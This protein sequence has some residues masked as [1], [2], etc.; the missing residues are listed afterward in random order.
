[1]FKTLGCVWEKAYAKFD[2]IQVSQAFLDDFNAG[3]A[4]AIVCIV[5]ESVE[6][7]EKVEFAFRHLFVQKAANISAINAQFRDGSRDR[8]A[9]IDSLRIRSRASA[10]VAWRTRSL[11]QPII[12]CIFSE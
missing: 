8:F 2:I 9:G 7:I 6:C 1:M 11:L 12:R 4:E 3:I 10:I 5:A